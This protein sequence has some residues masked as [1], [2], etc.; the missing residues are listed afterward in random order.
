MEADL[1]REMA[2]VIAVTC[3]LASLERQP[4]E[5][6]E[7]MLWLKNQDAVYFSHSQA[8]LRDLA[9][10]RR[11]V[12]EILLDDDTSDEEVGETKPS[13]PG[14]PRA[15]QECS[16]LEQ[17]LKKADLFEP[18][19]SH[20]GKV[21]QTWLG[22]IERRGQ[23]ASALMGILDGF[24][25]HVYRTS[26]DELMSHVT[27]LAMQVAPIDLNLPDDEDVFRLRIGR[28]LNDHSLVKKVFE[29]GIDLVENTHLAGTLL[30]LVRNDMEHPGVEDTSR[31]TLGELNLII[32]EAARYYGLG[33][34]EPLSRKELG[35][36][37]SRR[38][39]ETIVREFAKNTLRYCSGGPDLSRPRFP[40]TRNWG[41]CPGGGPGR[42]ELWK[43]TSE[44]RTGV[45]GRGP[46]REGVARLEGT[47]AARP[48][49]ASPRWNRV[50]AGRWPAS[51][52]WS[53]VC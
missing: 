5:S 41:N 24:N 30:E 8:Y 42:W 14:R 52:R 18:Q 6:S 11:K 28:A 20:Y 53:C 34:P 33:I 12:R 49:T 40:W 32:A 2:N 25:R 13:R 17:N 46:R 51:A 22:E 39:W 9:E 21:I 35:L 44:A 1:L 50:S 19:Q 45:L 27:E 31:T 48:R 37:G 38:V 10:H 15:L 16:N 26:A 7:P 43:G 4:D 47:P 29:T 23:H 36:R 3:S